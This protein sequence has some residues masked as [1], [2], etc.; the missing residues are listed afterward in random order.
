MK[1]MFNARSADLKEQ[2]EKAVKEEPVYT[3]RLVALR[4]H[5][6]LGMLQKKGYVDLSLA[7]AYQD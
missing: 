7:L 5:Q 2:I 4:L 3:H 1:D 6:T